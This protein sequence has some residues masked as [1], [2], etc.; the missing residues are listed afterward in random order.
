MAL[1]SHVTV[2]ELVLGF[3]VAAEYDSGSQG[4]GR[5]VDGHSSYIRQ[6]LTGHEVCPAHVEHSLRCKDI[7][8]AILPN[9]FPL[10]FR[11][12]LVP[13]QTRF[14]MVNAQFN[15]PFLQALLFGAEVV[16]IRVG[17]VVASPKKQFGLPLMIFC[18][19]L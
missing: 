7:V 13:G 1:V 3:L 14:L 18:E 11:Y 16:D 17:D 15:L 4:V 2:L 8:V 12:R 6:N 5:V 10:V 9:L 19:R